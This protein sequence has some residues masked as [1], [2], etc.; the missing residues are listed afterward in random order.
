MRGSGH[1]HGFLWSSTAP[2][3]D[4]SASESRAAFAEYWATFISAINPDQ[5]RPPD[6]RHPSALSYEDQLNTSELLTAC[7][8][9][10][11]RHRNC[12][13]S[14]CLRLKKG[15][16]GAKECRFYF[17]RSLRDEAAVSKDQNPHHWTFCP[18]RN[19]KLLNSYN[20]AMILAWMANIDTSPATSISVIVN[21]IGKYCSKEEKKSTS[22]QE[23][24][25]SVQPHANSLHAFSSVVAKFMNKLITKRD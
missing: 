15:C 3:P 18:Q 9:R 25:Q 13:E 10:F 23:L 5:S 14:Y 7:L 2:R 19:D 1:I 11:Q 12:T 21:Y 17:P 8:N 24:L 4:P 20:A 22:Y 16:I 6:L